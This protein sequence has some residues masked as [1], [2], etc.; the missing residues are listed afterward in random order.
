MAISDFLA[1]S[2]VLTGE[3]TLDLKLGEL[4]RNRLLVHYATTLE[5]LE[6][7]FK[8]FATDKDAEKKLQALLQKSPKLGPIARA[9]LWVWYTG[10]FKTPYETTDGPASHEPYAEG[11]L[12][13]V[14]HAHAPGYTNAGFGAWA[15]KPPGAQ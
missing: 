5:E 12:W 2:R 8:P 3:K 1:L 13:K 9:V 15:E 6:S 11:L 14:I 7:A 4:Y 10:E